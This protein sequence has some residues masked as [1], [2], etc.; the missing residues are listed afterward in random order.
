MKHRSLPHCEVKELLPG[1]RIVMEFSQHD[2]CNSAGVYLLHASHHHAHVAGIHKRRCCII[3]ENWGVLRRVIL[4]SPL[5]WY[6]FIYLISISSACIK[7]YQRT[8]RN[9]DTPIGLTKTSN[10][11][12]DATKA[13]H[14]RS[15][16]HHGYSSRLQRLRDGRSNLFG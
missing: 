12:M 11:N 14:S 5:F 13:E 1:C 15:L 3:D 2:T 9:Q 4:V 7:Q 6:L 10:Y 16:N 8:M